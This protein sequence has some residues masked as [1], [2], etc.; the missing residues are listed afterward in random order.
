MNVWAMKTMFSHWRKVKS[1]ISN[2]RNVLKIENEP[3]QRLGQSLHWL[4]NVIE[5]EKSW[6]EEDFSWWV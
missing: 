4:Q 1:L 5:I 2:L 3:G 6:K